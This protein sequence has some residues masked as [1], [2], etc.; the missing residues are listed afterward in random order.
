MSPQALPAALTGSPPSVGP[1]VDP[2]WP[3]LCYLE[4]ILMHFPCLLTFFFSPLHSYLDISASVT[5]QA[6]TEKLLGLLCFQADAR[7]I[8]TRSVRPFP[9]LQQRHIF[10]PPPQSTVLHP[11][12]G[13]KLFQ[14]KARDLEAKPGSTRIAT[15]PKTLRA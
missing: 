13:K 1:L 7:V 14:Q 12:H 8:P 15:T 9:R 10:I 4:R 11:R 6:H 5:T 3:F 2:A